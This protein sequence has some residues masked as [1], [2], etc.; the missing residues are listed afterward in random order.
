MAPKLV[1]LSAMNDGLPL[2]APE[3]AQQSGYLRIAAD[4]LGHSAT[5][6]GSRFVSG[7]WDSTLEPG[8]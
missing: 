4:Q 1:V 3:V 6:G 5:P 2:V 8:S 7:S